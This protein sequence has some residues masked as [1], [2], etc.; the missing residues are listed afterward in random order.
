M[1]SQ[2]VKVKCEKC[3]NEQVIFEKAASQVHCL[4]CN[5]VLAI[6]T[7]GKSDIKAKILGGVK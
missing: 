7:G 2:F 3:K 1:V 4:V 5:E 6:P